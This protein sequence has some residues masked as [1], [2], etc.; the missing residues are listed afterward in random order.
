MLSELSAF[1]SEGIRTA[2]AEKR[3]NHHVGCE[4]LVA[5]WSYGTICS[6][7]SLCCC[8]YQ[9]RIRQHRSSDA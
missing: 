5:L 9:R 7:D 3:N 4:R 6:L 2:V 1:V 8:I